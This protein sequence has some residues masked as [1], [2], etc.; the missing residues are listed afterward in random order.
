[1][2]L[3][4]TAGDRALGVAL[5]VIG[6]GVA[7]YL[8][9]LVLLSFAMQEPYPFLNVANKSGRP[10]LIEQADV[11]SSPGWRSSRLVWRSSGIWP[12]GKGS[13]EQDRL[14]ARDLTGTVVARRTGA[15]RSDTWTITTEGLSAAP[16]YPRLPV[17][18]GHVEVR[19][20]LDSSGT[21]DSVVAWWRALPQTLEGAAARGAAVGV[22]VHGPFLENEEL[23]MYVRGPD[24]GTVR[25][26]A[27]TQVLRP[28]PGRV[29]AYASSPGQPA[30]QTGVAELLVPTVA[31]SA[32]AR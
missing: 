11:V 9:M 8:A 6:V 5:I 19:L 3:S 7:G 18:P 21:E 24:A 31:P 12:A 10:L 13:C 32:R 22:T 26:F 1:M 23:A 16:R 28:S 29:Y 4:Q 25:D 15:C 2:G 27:R 30:P 17:P 20:V 14:V